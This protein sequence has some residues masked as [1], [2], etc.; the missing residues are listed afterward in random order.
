MKTIIIF[1][2]LFLIV[3]CNNNGDDTARHLKAQVVSYEK[4]AAADSLSSEQKNTGGN[5]YYIRQESPIIRNPITKRPIF[6]STHYVHVPRTYSTL[7]SKIQNS[8][9]QQNKMI[10]EMKKRQDS[11]QIRTTRTDLSTLPTL[12][13]SRQRASPS[14]EEY[15]LYTCQ[16]QAS[17]DTA[18]LDLE[19]EQEI[20]FF[21]PESTAPCSDYDR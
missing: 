18:G 16:Q 17:V 21:E 19:V 14:S 10:K 9:I 7:D 11:F 20:V 3:A 13:E 4:A 2:A 8:M 1:A 15:E 5:G 6:S 12:F